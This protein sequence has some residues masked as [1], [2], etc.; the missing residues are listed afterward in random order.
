MHLKTF[1]QMYML[2]INLRWLLILKVWCFNEHVRC[3]LMISFECVKVY[4]ELWKILNYMYQILNEK[5][6]IVKTENQT[7]PTQK[8]P[9]VGS[10]WFHFN[11]GRGWF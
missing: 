8:K 1:Y 5:I 4:V 6:T 3:N 7:E 9:P 11:L 10:C 2:L